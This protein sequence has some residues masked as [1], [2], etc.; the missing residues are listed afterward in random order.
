MHLPIKIDS[1]GE[2]STRLDT[3]KKA[4]GQ[5]F[6]M[7]GYVNT[8]SGFGGN[9]DPLSLTSFQVNSHLA[10]EVIANMYRYDWVARKYIDIIADDSTRKWIEFVSEDTDVMSAMNQRMDDLDVQ[11][12]FNEALILARLYGGSVIIPGINDGQKISEPLNW[13]NIKSINFMN[14]LDRWQVHVVKSYADPLGPDFGKPE[15]YSLQPINRSHG[16]LSNFTN[17][18]KR[19]QVIH[20][21]RIIRLDGLYIPD[22][23][24]VANQGWHD[25]FL[26]PL[27]QTLKDFGVSIHSLSVLFMDFITKVLKLPG[28]AELV[29]D[30]VGK[31]AIEGRISFMAQKMSSIGI[32]LIGED[33][34]FDKKQSPVSGLDKLFDK[35][36]EILSGATGI[37]RSRF[38]SQQLGKLAGATEETKKYYESIAAY[39]TKYLFNPIKKMIKLI[40]NDKSFETNGNE[41]ENWSFSFKSLM[42]MDDKTRS[43]FRKTTVEWVNGLID[44]G[45][46]TAEE[47]TASLFSPTGFSDNIIIDWKLKEEFKNAEKAIKEE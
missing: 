29:K 23:L 21:S 19:N 27:E 25:S 8:V 3:F 46:I 36:M 30:D 12:A 34:E 39:Q 37:P 28:L 16:H 2:E 38:F 18:L 41:P 32:A 17:L 40:L 31:A 14:V 7:D 20:E 44:R 22:I 1:M 24:R 33:E 26:I 5:F 11:E 10:R 6:R 13:E 45:V 42:E 35:E 15:L 4:F 9:N 47:V 43:E